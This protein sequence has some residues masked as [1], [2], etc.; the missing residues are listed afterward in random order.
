M[1]ESKV[2][3][4]CEEILEDDD[5]ERVDDDGYS[6]SELLDGA[7]FEYIECPITVSGVQNVTQIVYFFTMGWER[8][9]IQPKTSCNMTQK[10][11]LK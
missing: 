11:N 5:G 7:Y 9:T 4:G 3:I 6:M 8:G 10:R 1:I 2:N